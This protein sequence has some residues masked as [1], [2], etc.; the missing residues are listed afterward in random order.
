MLSE[1]VQYQGKAGFFKSGPVGSGCSSFGRTS[2]SQDK[3]EIPFL[4]K[5][6]NKQKC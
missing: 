5:V 4:Q 6:N 1:L 2:F 3:N